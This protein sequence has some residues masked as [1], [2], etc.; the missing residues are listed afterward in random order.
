MDMELVKAFFMGIVQGLT[1]FFPISSTAHLILMPKFFDWAGQLDSLSFDIA[2]HA[3]TLCSLLFCFYKDWINMLMSDRRL[4]ML[5]MIGTIPAGLVGIFFKDI[6]EGSLRNPGYIAAAL[7]AGSVIMFA[8]E[9]YGAKHSSSSKPGLFDAIFI[10]IAQAV[11]LIPGISRSGITI[12]AGLF[13]KF[14]R[15][16]AARF[17]FLLST[18]AI[19]GAAMLETR[20]MIKAP[21]Q[22]DVWLVAVGFTASFISGLFAIKFLMSFLKKHPLN[23]FIYYRLALAGA[24]LL[25]FLLM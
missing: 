22:L 15:P 19:A 9:K 5:L 7:V 1:E 25:A 3:G 14:D 16:S 12:S 6:I 24:I 11:A 4:L 23:I 20:H 21:E 18:P 13:R 8:A 10:G 17:S 2:L